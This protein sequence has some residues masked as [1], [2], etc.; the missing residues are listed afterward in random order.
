MPDQIKNE[1]ASSRRKKIIYVEA[2]EQYN[3]INKHV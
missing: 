3:M 2:S 1:R